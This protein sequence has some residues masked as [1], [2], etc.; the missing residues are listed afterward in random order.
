MAFYP[1]NKQ[2]LKGE[3]KTLKFSNFRMYHT[4]QYCQLLL[5]YDLILDRRTANILTKQMH[6]HK[7]WEW[8]KKKHWP[9]SK[10]NA[11]KPEKLSTN[12]HVFTWLK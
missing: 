10:N 7:S 11:E 2:I 4:S 1:I 6:V 12:K 5:L 3:R 9:V 8:G